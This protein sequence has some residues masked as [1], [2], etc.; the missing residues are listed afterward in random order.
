[1]TLVNVVVALLMLAGLAGAVLPVLPGTPLIVAGAL[2]HAV[3]TE[4]TPI[5]V[6]RLAILV[7]L[8]VVGAVLSQAAAAL[9][10]RRAGGSRWA[11]VGALLGAVVGVFTAPLGLLLGPL[12]GAVA[13]EIVRT[14]R[15]R[16]SVRAGVGALVGLALGAAAQVAVS[17]VMVGLFVW[18]VRGG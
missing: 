18:W 4:F 8:A 6:G 1:V 10:V 2:L 16:G 15:L 7:G 3:A 14:R 13:G 12:L 5:G 17:F 9:G 11:M